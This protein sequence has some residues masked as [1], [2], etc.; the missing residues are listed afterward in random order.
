MN[1]GSIRWRLPREVGE[2]IRPCN[3]TK[4]QAAFDLHDD[5]NWSAV[6][7]SS[8]T[9]RPMYESDS[10]K[11]KPSVFEPMDMRTAEALLKEAKAVLH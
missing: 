10:G 3:L 5:W 9:S 4:F 1:H 6:L 7:S 8:E 11:T 2:C